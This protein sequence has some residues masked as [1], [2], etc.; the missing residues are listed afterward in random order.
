MMYRCFFILFALIACRS[1]PG[2]FL[3]LVVELES[4]VYGEFLG[5]EPATVVGHVSDPTA[6]VR[7]EGDLV[8][9]NSDGRFEVTVPV[10]DHFRNIDVYATRETQV[11]RERIPVFAGK[12]PM[13]TWPAALTARLTPSG[14]GRIG[15]VLG[16]QIDATDWDQMLVEAIPAI[17]S[18]SFYLGATD[19]THEPTEVL[20]RPVEGGIDIGIS[21]KEV[22]LH[23]EA[24]VSLFGTSLDVPIVVGYEL[25]ELGAK[26]TPAINDDGVITLELSDT[27]ILFDEPIIEAF[28]VDIELLDFL[29]DGIN[30]IIELVGEF[31][32][33]QIFGLLGELEVAGPLEFEADLMGTPLNIS[34]AE[35]YGETEGLGMG[36]GV[37]LGEPAPVA[38]L[39]LWAP[40]ESDRSPKEVHLALGLHEGLVQGM[41]DGQ[42]LEMLNQELELPGS[43]GSIIGLAMQGLPGGEQTP[44]ADGWC[45]Q[46]NAGDARVFRMQEGIAPMGRL[47]L[48]DVTVEIGSE[49]GG[50][51][52]PWLVTSLTMDVALVVKNGTTVGIDLSIPEGIVLEYGAEGPWVESEVVEG[53]SSLVQTMMSL[54]GGQLSFDLA[55]LLGDLGSDDS[56]LGIMGE[57]KPSIVWNEPFVAGGLPVPE[58]TYNLS[59]SLWDVE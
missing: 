47:I 21:L 48:P 39:Q 28:G 14:M 27:F 6:M 41:L 19:L 45:L 40:L 22:E 4:P 38:P 18:G 57:L 23:L 24:E 7:I 49:M 43:M 25:I 3:D 55:E 15:Q 30:Y 11:V 20:L 29:F 5:D 34:L 17:D 2:P 35:V 59:I 36:L 10:T 53:L 44:Y 31:L 1:E 12:D 42:L 46:L 56:L 37:G 50:I 26:A 32:L 9:V 33:D 58:G 51:C 13:E 52:E 16:Q 8:D 54:L